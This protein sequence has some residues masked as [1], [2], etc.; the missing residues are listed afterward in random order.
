MP[1]Q[2]KSLE[3]I[4]P[5]HFRVAIFGSARIKHNDPRYIQIYSLAKQIAAH[6]MDVVTGG[7]PGI[8][9]AANKGH[10]E[11]RGENKVHSVGLNI[12]LP[13]EQQSNIH[14]DIKRDYKRF[15]SRLDSFMKLS[16]VVVVA[17]GGI[18]T[19]L[20]LMYTWQLVQVKH[21]CNTPIILLGKMWKPFIEWMEQYPVK[22]KFVSED[23]MNPIFLADHVREAMKII[24]KAHKEFQNRGEDFCWNYRQYKLD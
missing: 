24:K 17:P 2:I 23:E 19:I 15:S 13:H 8:M 5:G 10:K 22:N 9:E 12:M 21:I 18:G 1:K 16:N 11:G 7:G 4:D 14:L 6:N 3:H 20:E